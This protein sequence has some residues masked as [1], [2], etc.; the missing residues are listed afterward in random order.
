MGSPGN[1][2]SCL[3]PSAQPSPAPC[4][5][6][7][8]TSLLRLSGLGSTLGGREPPE[9]GGGPRDTGNHA[10]EGRWF[11]W[12]RGQPAGGRVCARTVGT[13]AEA[14]GRRGLGWGWPSPA[15]APR[16]AQA[17][18]LPASGAGPHPSHPGCPR[19]RGWSRKSGEWE[20]RLYPQGRGHGREDRPAP[21][22]PQG[23]TADSR[24]PHPARISPAQR[25]QA[26]R[27]SCPG[28]FL[29]ARDE[30]A[31]SRHRVGGP[32]LEPHLNVGR[33]LAPQD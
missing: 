2:A 29:D 16:P 32:A 27:G 26:A 10:P 7:P 20:V 6:C 9:R 28:L 22:T 21:P 18:T 11:G 15:G 24:G 5:Q 12:A 1:A 4:S 8:E 19:T 30:K 3:G 25:L 23:E 13:D 14:T 31:A 17:L 33:G